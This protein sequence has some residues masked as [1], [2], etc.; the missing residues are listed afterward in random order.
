MATM[1]SPIRH[2]EHS[3]KVE[4]FKARAETESVVFYSQERSAHPVQMTFKLG[5][6][7]LFLRFALANLTHNQ[8]Q[9]I[10]A[11]QDADFTRCS[12]E[13]LLKKATSLQKISQRG[14]TVLC[15]LNSLG[16]SK[17][18]CA[19]YLPQLEDQVEHFQSISDSLR[20]A[21]DTEASLLMGFAVEQMATH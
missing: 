7:A 1:V 3:V 8:K 4:S 12:D 19:A 2:L 21:A 5:L 6:T 17:K 13:E 11:Y 20:I 9:L 14:R 15:M 10:R 18:F 16:R